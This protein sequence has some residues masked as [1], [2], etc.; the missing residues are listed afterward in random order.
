MQ[1]SHVIQA[2]TS[3]ECS[4]LGFEPDDPGQ[5]A[6]LPAPPVLG[7][8][9]QKRMPCEEAN[10]ARGRTTV[11]RL[12]MNDVNGRVV[13]GTPSAGAGPA[14]EINV[15]VIEKE[16]FVEPAHVLEAFSP[17]HP[18]TARDPGHQRALVERLTHVLA[19]LTRPKQTRQGCC[20]R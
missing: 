3:L 16:A 20:E 15:L 6:K 2:G 9:G 11:Q 4:Q 1:N 10:R 7:G 8:V 12:M 13:P 5:H 17:D 18:A 14:A 19:P